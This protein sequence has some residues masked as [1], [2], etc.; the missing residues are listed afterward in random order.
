[1]SEQSK[2]VPCGQCGADTE[3]TREEYKWVK[4]ALFCS[5]ECRTKW[6]NANFYWDDDEWGL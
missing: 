6:V 3:T 1:M 5:K 2:F 4:P